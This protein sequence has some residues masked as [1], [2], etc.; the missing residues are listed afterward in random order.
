[1]KKRIILVLVIAALFVSINANAQIKFGVKAGLNISNMSIESSG[2]SVT[3]NS[4]TSFHIGL[5]V[6]YAFKPELSIQSGILYSGKGTSVDNPL[7][8]GSDKMAPNYLEI[9]VNIAYKLAAGPG[10][11]VL[12]GGP[13]LGIGI[14]GQASGVDIKWGSGTGNDLQRTDLGLNFGAGYEINKFLISAQYGFSLTN[15][16]ADTNTTVKNKVT[17]ISVAYFFN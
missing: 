12:F 6:D 2:Y 10:K 5:A 9:P 3:P 7:T 11:V 17:G 16:N 4:I 8:G 14:S 15:V 13:Y 1:M